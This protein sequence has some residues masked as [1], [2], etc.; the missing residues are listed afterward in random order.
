MKLTSHGGLAFLGEF[1]KAIGIREIINQYLPCPKSNRG[2]KPWVYIEGIIHLLHAG[3]RCLEDFRELWRESELFKILGIKKI[4]SSDAVGL[5]LRRMGE[6]ERGISG[7]AQ[8]VKEINN[9]IMSYE[10]DEGYTLDVDA[11]EIIAEKQ[12]SF[13]TYRGNR[14]YMPVLGFLYENG[15][16][17]YDEF[18]EGNISPGFGMV[19][20][21]KKC[22]EM[23][24]S[25]KRIKY[26]RSDSASYQ[27]KVINVLED[28]GVYFT[29]TANMDISVKE[30]IKSIR[31]EEW[32]EPEEGCG[33]EIAEGVHSMEKT[34]K[35]F[36]L[37]VKR[38]KVR[39]LNLFEPYE[40]Y[41]Y[42]AVATNLS[43]DKRPHEVLR[44]HNQRGQMENFIKELKIGFG[45]ER[46][47]SG[48]SYANALFLRIGVLAYNIFIGF[49]RIVLKKGWI[50]YRILTMRW[51]FFEVAGKIVRHGG[52][53][54]LKLGVRVNEIRFF[55]EVRRRIYNLFVH[56]PPV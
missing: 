46:M 27:A 16:C 43:E 26:Y 41:R 37:I 19:E 48:K 21:Y 5:W 17:I 28:E 29:I 42:Y 30:L 51:K 18:R 54:L 20:F 45:M 44:F 12:E 7:V 23:M 47:P 39:Q 13:Y 25:Y 50:R 55:L 56:A 52:L 34:K 3:G 33:Y 40:N 15:I 6:D 32:Y 53:I 38:E 24:P 49:K 4:P 9:R 36:R 31:G 11:T 8:V 14:G 35:A 1:M 22:K 2:Y 10:E